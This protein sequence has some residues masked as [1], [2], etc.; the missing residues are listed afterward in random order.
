MAMDGDIDY[1]GFSFKELEEALER[2]HKDRFSLNYQRLIAEIQKRRSEAEKS[3][4]PLSEIYDKPIVR[5]R[6]EFRGDPKEYF[7]IW[8]V[9]LALTIL[10]LGI[11]SAWAKVR[12]Q[13]YFYLST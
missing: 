13:R 6:P 5:H 4:L 9:N 11:Y 1:S 2:I 8:I 12:K 10:T 7:R 3:N